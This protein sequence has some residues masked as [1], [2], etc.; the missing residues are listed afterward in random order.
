M[1]ILLDLNMNYGEVLEFILFL[2]KQESIPGVQITHKL[3]FGA[4]QRLQ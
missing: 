3:G 2:K 4:S 1:S